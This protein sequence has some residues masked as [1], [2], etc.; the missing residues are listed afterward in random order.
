MR[1]LLSMRQLVCP[2]QLLIALA[3]ALLV[4]MAAGKAQAAA[5]TDL[6]LNTSSGRVVASLTGAP[7]TTYS[8]WRSSGG[9]TFT[10]VSSYTTGPAN[11]AGTAVA[12]WTEDP[13]TKALT[14]SDTTVQDYFDYTYY[15]QNDSDAPATQTYRL[16]AFPPTQTA[17]GSYTLDTNACAGCHSTH[18]AQGAAL[19]R[20]AT[21]DATCRTCHNG[22]GSKYNVGD[23]TV[24][25]PNGAGG[26][27]AK[28]TQG[29]PFGGQDGFAYQGASPV[30]SRHKVGTTAINQAPG[31]NYGSTGPG[32]ADTLTCGSCHDP[33]GTAHNYRL[34]REALLDSPN[35]QVQAVPAVVVGGDETVTY[36][37]GMNTFCAACHKDF[38]VGAGSGSTPP[39]ETYAT[40]AGTYRHAVGI[41][42]AGKGL[43][44]TFPLEGAAGNNT[45][46]IFCLTCHRAHGTTATGTNPSGYDQNGDG[47][48]TAADVTT[49]LKRAN[50]MTVCEDCHKK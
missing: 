40:T 5:P 19:L 12:G 22:T 2:R 15:V 48:V 33:H 6:R 45:D 28:L 8:I 34:L 38:N 46:L 26:T 39:P 37:K 10:Q 27:M 42:P 17:H 47:S 43:T 20:E 14:Y 36:V 31:G 13:A 1:R 30:T 23:G 35:I 16:A 44:T 24:L 49:W 29:G 25:V 21:V 50:N 7:S 11:Q 18:T 9:G 41:A 3:G 4:L 32:W